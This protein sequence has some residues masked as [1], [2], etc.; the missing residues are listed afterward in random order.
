VEIT[1]FGETHTLEFPIDM[2]ADWDSR[3]SSLGRNNLVADH[4][5]DG[6]PPGVHLVKPS[7]AIEAQHAIARGMQ[8]PWRAVR[9]NPGLREVSAMDWHVENAKDE[10]LLNNLDLELLDAAA[11]GEDEGL[12]NLVG[13]HNAR[14]L[15]LTERF[16]RLATDRSQMPVF[17]TWVG[18]DAADILGERYRLV[19]ESWNVLV[20]LRNLLAE[21][22]DI[23]RRMEA[24]ARD[25]TDSLLEHGEEVVARTRKSLV[26]ASREYLA[27]NPIVGQSYLVDLIAEDDAVV[28]A[29]RQTA[30]AM[31]LLE[32]LR[33][34]RR[35]AMAGMSAVTHRQREVFRALVNF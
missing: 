33:S 31:N 16:S 19:Q 7:G 32:S 20:A 27:A 22:Q 35:G 13:A 30:D 18:R 21:R 26:K 25:R 15:G 12:A 17:D 6:V 8:A 34:S 29:E 9:E 2:T 3:Q 28:A 11:A 23:L 14:L 5:L 4:I 1:A 10:A 24:T